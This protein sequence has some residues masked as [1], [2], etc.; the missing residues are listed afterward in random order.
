MHKKLMRHMSQNMNQ[1]YNDN[2]KEPKV[3]ENQL[4]ILKIS[5]FCLKTRETVLGPG[6]SFCRITFLSMSI[7]PK[8]CQIFPLKI[9]T[10]LLIGSRKNSVGAQ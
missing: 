8:S 2:T 3:K 4:G 9:A 5:T 1:V 7:Q 6:E 10:T